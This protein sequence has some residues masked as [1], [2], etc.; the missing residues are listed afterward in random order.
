MQVWDRNK[1]GDLR[2]DLNTV[3]SNDKL[4]RYV[5]FFEFL[6]TYAWRGRGENKLNS[7]FFQN[8]FVNK[9]FEFEFKGGGGG[10]GLK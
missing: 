6:G 10:L 8:L 4:F 7:I 3:P 2:R 9:K 1:K 5:I